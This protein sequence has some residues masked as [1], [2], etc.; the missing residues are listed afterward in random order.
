MKTNVIAM[1]N[2]TKTRSVNLSPVRG[3]ARNS[4]GESPLRFVTYGS[5]NLGG[6]QSKTMDKETEVKMVLRKNLP[7][8]LVRA[9]MT[10]SQLSGNKGVFKSV[11]CGW[12]P[13]RSPLNLG[14]LRRVAQQFGITLGALCFGEEHAKLPNMGSPFR[15][16]A[17]KFE[18]IVKR[19]PDVAAL[20]LTIGDR[21]NM[22]QILPK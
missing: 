15:F 13:G 20:A 8:Y 2:R 17:G 18:V 21:D 11:L 22:K 5:K 16:E 14:A 4:Y 12:M 1:P 9:G 10:A 6:L 7:K 3:H 19:I